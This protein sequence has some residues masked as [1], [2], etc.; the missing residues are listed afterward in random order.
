MQARITTFLYQKIGLSP[1][2]LRGGFWLVIAQIVNSFASFVVAVV[3]G[4]IITKET[5][6]EYRYLISI[7]SVLSLI[8]ISGY[9]IVITQLVAKGDNSIWWRGVKKTFFSSMLASLVSFVAAFYYH[10]NGNALL[11]GGFIVIGLGLPLLNAVQLYSAYLSGKKD[12]KTLS[13]YGI[14]PDLSVMLTLILTALYFKSAVALLI[15]FFISNIISH[16]LINYFTYRKYPTLPSGP[17]IEES[18]YP[19]HLSA[20]NFFN[21]LGQNVDKL[22]AFHFLGAA[23]VAI[24]AFAQAIPLQLKGVQKIILSLTLPKFAENSDRIVDIR[25]KIYYMTG[26]TVLLL[27][28]YILLAPFIYRFIFPNYVE[29]IFVSQVFSLSVI[30]LPTIYLLQSYLNANTKTKAL[31]SNTFISNIVTIV[32]TFIGIYYFGLLGAAVASIFSN[33]ITALNLVWLYKKS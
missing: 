11:A 6:G 14:F 10:L 4:Y 27:A 7:M 21:M 32:C 15:V 19:I 17:A 3:L 5:F 9:N 20:M 8:A 29:S 18:S 26:L 24:L 31:Y 2:F 22:L 12:F 33:A 23:P 16:G 30:F 1:Y 13:L 28:I 25:K